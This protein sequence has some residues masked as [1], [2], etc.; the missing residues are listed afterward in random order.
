MFIYYNRKNDTYK[1]IP[2]RVAASSQLSTEWLLRSLLMARKWSRGVLLDIGC[3]DKPYRDLFEARRYI[4]GDWPDSPH[5]SEGIDVFMDAS[6]LPFKSSSF[7]T[8]IFTEVLEHLADPHRAL[9]EISRVMKSDGKV[10]LSVPFVHWIHESPHDYYRYTEYGLKRVLEENGLEVIEQHN[11][12][13][14]LTVALDISGRAVSMLLSQVLKKLGVSRA[15]IQMTQRVMVAWPQ[16]LYAKAFFIL[17]HWLPRL[18]GFLD[19]SVRLT[20]GYV[21]VA[22]RR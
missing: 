14:A 21:I 11:R 2:K 4:G 3:G 18:A 8:V 7:H 16:L 22:R 5:A 6:I 1:V 10:I 17:Y 20:L 19:P 15:L 9:R 13:G 12:G